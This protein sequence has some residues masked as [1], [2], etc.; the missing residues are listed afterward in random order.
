MNFS[1]YVCL[2][3]LRDRARQ[4]IITHWYLTRE[5]CRTLWGER[6]QAALNCNIV[7]ALSI[8]YQITAHNPWHVTKQ[9]LSLHCRQNDLRQGKVSQLQRIACHGVVS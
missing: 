4:K 2:H 7:N 3:G 5:I 1:L 6:G 8:K 9:G